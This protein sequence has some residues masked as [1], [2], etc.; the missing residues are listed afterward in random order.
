MNT[1]KLVCRSPESILILRCIARSGRFRR[2][3]SR[4]TL[5]SEEISGAGLAGGQ[6]RTDCEP[7]LRHGVREGQVRPIAVSPNKQEPVHVI[8]TEPISA[9][10]LP[11]WNRM[12]SHTSR[13]L[14]S[15]SHPWQGRRATIVSRV[16]QTTL[17]QHQRVALRPRDGSR[18]PPLLDRTRSSDEPRRIVFAETRH[19]SEPFI[20]TAHRGQNVPFYSPAIC[21]A[22]GVAAD[23]GYSP[24]PAHTERE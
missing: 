6:S 7:G 17:A 9:G 14:R 8:S 12:H 4:R 19:R 15:G 1:G 16:V 11:A 23:V 20:T 2:C 22:E 3:G 21:S 5:D 13:T 18:R 24:M 10:S